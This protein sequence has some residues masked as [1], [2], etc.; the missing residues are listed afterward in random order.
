MG[1]ICSSLEEVR[2]HIDRTDDEIIRLIAERSG[3][4]RQAA[5]FKKDTASVKAPAR[6][7]AVIQRIREKEQRY[8]LSQDIA[9]KIYRQMIS[10]FIE[11]ETDVFTDNQN[12][13]H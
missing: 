6:V 7:E 8:G 1:H 9:E 5:A 2:E 10:C 12:E 13:N 4:V 11:M 3:Y